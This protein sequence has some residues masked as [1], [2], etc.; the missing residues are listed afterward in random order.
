MVLLA[1]VAG[2]HVSRIFMD[3]GSGT[4]LIYARTL[5]AMNI[6]LD[7]LTATDTS[8]HGIVLGSPNIPL[9]KIALDV[10]FGT[11]QNFSREKL[12]VKVMD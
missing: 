5:T 3:V 2:Y 1:Q 8:F 11:R 9:G 10:V 7:N 6:S 12:E 4:K